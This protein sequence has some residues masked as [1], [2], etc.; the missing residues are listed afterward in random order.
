MDQEIDPQA[1]S[2]HVEDDN[3]EGMRLAARESDHVVE[4]FSNR[5]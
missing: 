3:F 5:A 1:W 2:V 4:E